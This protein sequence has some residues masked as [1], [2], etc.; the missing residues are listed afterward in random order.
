VAVELCAVD[1]ELLSFRSAENP[2]IFKKAACII[3]VFV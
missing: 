1:A 3:I 2:Q